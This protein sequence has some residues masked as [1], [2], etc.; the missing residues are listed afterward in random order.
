M[1]MAKEGCLLSKKIISVLATM[2]V[3]T[4]LLAS[5]G[6]GKPATSGVFGIVVINYPSVSKP[7]TPSP[8]PG[9]FGLSG[10][11][12]Y[13]RATVVVRA[14]SGSNSG[15]VVARIRPDSRGL[16]RVNLAPGRYTLSA[17]GYG[18]PLSVVVRA[19]AFTRAVV[20][21]GIFN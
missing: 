1:P 10:M 4:A 3:V 9:G 18:V 2:L 16:F 6:G 12:P 13:P 19:G 11:Q 21:G 5:C 17:N 15:R 14:T 20:Q 7:A 8:L